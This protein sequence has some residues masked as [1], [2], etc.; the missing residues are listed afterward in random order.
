MNESDKALLK[1][2]VE[3]AEISF[4]RFDSE[5]YPNN[6]LVA[7]QVMLRFAQLVINL[8]SDLT[9]KYFAAVDDCMPGNPD[10]GEK[11][12]KCSKEYI[13]AFKSWLENHP[14]ESTA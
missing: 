12:I 4:N 14:T 3:Q 11:F 6:W 7:H 13:Q 10:S 2:M 5:N 8:V 1:I 9:N